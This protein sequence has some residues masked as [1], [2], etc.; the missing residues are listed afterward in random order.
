MP[1]SASLLFP[2]PPSQQQQQ[3][4]Q[5][6][7]PTPSRAHCIPQYG[8]TSD[9][10]TNSYKGKGSNTRGTNLKPP[11]TPTPSTVGPNGDDD[12]LYLLWTHQLLKER[13]SSMDIDA[14]DHSSTD[15]SV[16]DD[17][18][19][20]DDGY[21]THDNGTASHRHPWTISYSHSSSTSVYK[22][23]IHMSTS[24]Y[25]HQLSAT[26]DGSPAT[27]IYGVEDQK[28]IFSRWWRICFPCNS[29]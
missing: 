1:Q 4:Q 25:S 23:S 27:A 26:A 29:K 13:R 24:S 3:Q 8:A 16:T 17:D 15:S 7:S 5:P 21:G 22:P 20:D 11:V 18:D 14:S 9:T 12:G 2:P 6:A 10:S 28:H 19:D